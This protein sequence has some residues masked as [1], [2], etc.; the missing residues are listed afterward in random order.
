MTGH[1]ATT[2]ERLWRWLYYG[3]CAA[4]LVFLIAP[5]LAII[6]LSFNSE[7]FFTYPLRGVSL[8]WYAQFAESY[9]WRLA[10]SNSLIIAGATVVLATALGTLAAVGLTVANFP[11]KG[12]LIALLISPMMV[13]HI[14]TGLGM[15]FLYSWLGAVQTLWGIIFAHTTVAAPFVVLTV[16]TSLA[17][18]RINLLRAAASLGASPVATF[19]RV[20]LPIIMPSVVA[21]AL[22]AFVVS[23]D[24]LIIALLLSGSDQRTLPRQM[25]AGTQEEIT[26]VI[27]AVATVLM[28]ISIL[29]AL[30]MQWMQRR[31][32]R[33]KTHAN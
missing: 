21:G 3:F 20:V 18:F 6:P 16:A 10:F 19:F 9:E 23:F 26:P 1:A 33:M 5:M 13:P 24:E 14:I 2:L 22:F 25:W 17:H 28:C 4:L 31:G 32:E 11:G 8:R 15:F 12:A 27:T 7:P 30:A 29:L